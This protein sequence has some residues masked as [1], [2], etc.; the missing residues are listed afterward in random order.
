MGYKLPTLLP[1]DLRLRGVTYGALLLS[2]V[3]AVLCDLRY[4]T[5]RLKLSEWLPNSGA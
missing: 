1:M 2:N 3:Y 4:F 5:S